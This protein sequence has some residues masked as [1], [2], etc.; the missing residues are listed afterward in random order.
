MEHALPEAFLSKQIN[1]HVV[2]C[3]GTGSQV[4]AGLA[5][6]H[7]TMLELGHPHGLNVTVWD[8]DTIE[9]H[10]VGRQLFFRPDVGMNKAE[11]MVYRL[12][13]AFGLAWQA[14]PCRFDGTRHHQIDLII[15]CVDTKASRNSI[16]QAVQD[17]LNCYWL[18]FGNRSGDGQVILGLGG[19]AADKHPMRLPLPT[20]L[21][22]ELVDGEE[23]VETP[24]CS[25]RASIARQGLFLNQQVATWG[26]DILFRLFTKGRL[27][28]HGVFINTDNAAV[29]RITVDPATWKRFGYDSSPALEAA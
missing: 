6:L 16:Q 9:E 15:G 24:T 12:N 19:R 3:G 17:T 27:S 1:I 14:I 22:P 5:R 20:E 21:L 23:D 29:T 11:V 2:G 28:W 10:N 25:V 26:L 4:V 18:D 13:V 8:D 7:I